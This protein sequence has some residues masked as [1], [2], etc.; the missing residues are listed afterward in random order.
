MIYIGLGDALV[1]LKVQSLEDGAPILELMESENKMLVDGVFRAMAMLRLVPT[2][3]QI[4]QILQVVKMKPIDD[5]GR[6]WPLAAAPGWT[7]D[8]VQQ[9]IDESLKSSA[10]EIVKAAEFAAEKKYRKWSP[11]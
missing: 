4:D 10:A 7:G 11:L 1:R 8:N 3:A 6:I 5:P 9:F 2:P